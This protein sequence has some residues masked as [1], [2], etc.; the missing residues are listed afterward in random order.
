MRFYQFTLG[1]LYDIEAVGHKETLCE[2]HSL[3]SPGFQEPPF[4]LDINLGAIGR[5]DTIGMQIGE[6]DMG[7]EIVCK[8]R[9]RPTSAQ[10]NLRP[11]QA[12]PTKPNLPPPQD[13]RSPR[14]AFKRE[15]HPRMEIFETLTKHAFPL[16]NDLVSPIGG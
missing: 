16:S 6:N 9:S 15:E 14:F 11:G 8:V 1:R 7:M 12:P 3:L 4:V 5:L 13:M 10:A 2:T